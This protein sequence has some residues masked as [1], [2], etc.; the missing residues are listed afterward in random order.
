M[1]KTEY[2]LRREYGLETLG[3]KKIKKFEKFKYLKMHQLFFFNDA[4]S[5]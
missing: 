5:C 3:V 2:V 1:I 4:T